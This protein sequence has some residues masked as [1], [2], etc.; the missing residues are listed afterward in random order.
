LA[1]NR[2]RKYSEECNKYIMLHI[3]LEKAALFVVFVF[4]GWL[5]WKGWFDIK[6]GQ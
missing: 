6:D 1:A 3:L 4:G 5:L 2:E